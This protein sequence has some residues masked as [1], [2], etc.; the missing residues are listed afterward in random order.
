MRCSHCGIEVKE[1]DRVCKNCGKI[2]EKK[3]YCLNCRKEYPITEEFCD[4]C[5]IRL[6]DSLE[7]SGEPTQKKPE[8]PE[9]KETIVPETIKSAKVEIPPQL[10]TTTVASEKLARIK[11][12]LAKARLL[13]LEGKLLEAKDACLEILALTSSEK[14]PPSEIDT[15][16]ECRK[17]LESIKNKRKEM[18][19]E[20]VKKLLSDEK[21]QEAIKI[22]DQ[23]CKDYPDDEDLKQIHYDAMESAFQKKR[24]DEEEKIKGDKTK[25]KEQITKISQTSQNFIKDGKIVKALNCLKEILKIEPENKEIKEQAKSLKKEL[26]RLRRK[27]LIK[28]AIIS[29]VPIILGII[30]FGLTFLTTELPLGNEIWFFVGITG[31]AIGIC[32]LLIGIIIARLHGSK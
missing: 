9:K 16:S 17:I 3:K 8:Q 24:E 6:V 23:L 29:A 11:G 14:Y 7:T 19:L 5:G 12:L 22:C 27:K 10:E 20:T 21:Y 25:R 2:I 18:G 13:E 28:F 1:L 15:I 30:L 26:I 4:D 32:I 31:I